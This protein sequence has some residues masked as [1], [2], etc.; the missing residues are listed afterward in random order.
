MLWRMHSAFF[1]CLYHCSATF[2]V[3]MSKLESMAPVGHSGTHFPQVLHVSGLIYARLSATCIAPNGHALAHLPQPIH[4][5]VHNFRAIAPLSRLEQATHTRRSLRPTGRSSMSLRG[6][7]DTHAPHAVQSEVSTT[8]SPVALSMLRAPK[9]HTSAQSPQPS[10]PKAHPLVPTAT[11]AITAH[12]CAPSYTYFNGR[13]AHEPLQRN[14]ATCRDWSGKASMPRT[15]A[16]F[17]IPSAPE[18][19]Q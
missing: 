15:S 14:T 19:G 12:D 10:H 18:T 9:A 16:I 13:A 11:D 17:A 5:A 6:H 8:G 3:G 4:A 1:E 2:F 7:S